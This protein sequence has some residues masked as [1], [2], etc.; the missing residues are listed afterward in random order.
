MKPNAPNVSLAPQSAPSLRG[1]CNRVHSLSTRVV[2]VVAVA[3]SSAPALAA[4]N[5]P[6]GF[7]LVHPK[8][9]EA[10]L[11]ATCAE[12]DASLD[13]LDEESGDLEG[14]DLAEHN[15]KLTL[16]AQDGERWLLGGRVGLGVSALMILS[17]VT[18]V[19]VNVRRTREFEL[20]TQTAITDLEIPPTD[21]EAPAD[22]IEPSDPIVPV[23]RLPSRALGVGGALMIIGGLGGAGAS[24]W[25]M[26]RGGKQIKSARAGQLT[27]QYG[28]GRVGLGYR[29]RF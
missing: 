20:A 12:R 13:F 9:T 25:A 6:A 15:G 7:A 16:Q 8:P 4:G 27:F 3:T 19:A 21:P 18:M 24:V 28:G 10:Q 5:T 22:P 2:V 1:R 17:G 26:L 14:D 23:T 29:G 11:E